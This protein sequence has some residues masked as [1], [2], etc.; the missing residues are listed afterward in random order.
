[1]VSLL[2]P[3]AP[4]WLSLLSVWCFF[5][6]TPWGQ[7]WTPALTLPHGH[8]RLS[9][10]RMAVCCTCRRPSMGRHVHRQL[11]HSKWVG[12][13]RVALRYVSP[14]PPLEPGMRLL[15]RTAHEIGTL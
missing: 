1:M 4:T 6:A 14:I 7:P 11:P 8:D 9:M 2:L 12:S 15:P 3:C 10:R 5:G 13:G